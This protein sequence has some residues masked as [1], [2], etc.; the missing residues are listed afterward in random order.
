MKKLL[1]W[2]LVLC[3][4]FSLIG[5]AASDP[6]KTATTPVSTTL[7]GE[8]A[9]ESLPAETAPVATGP[10][11][12]AA[13][14]SQGNTIWLF[15]SIHVGREDFYPL[16]D[17]VM[18]AYNEADALAVEADIVA[19]E[20]N[21]AAATK[22]ILGTMYKDGTKVADHI[23]A[24]LYERSVEILR[25]GGM[26]MPTMDMFH[27]YTW[28]SSIQELAMKKLSCNMSLGIDRHLIQNAKDTGKT[29]LE[30]ESVEFQ[31][32]ILTGF[33]DEINALSLASAIDMYDDPE[34]ADA[35]ITEMMDLWQSGDEAA[36]AAYLASEDDSMP[37]EEQA[38]YAQ[39]MQVL[40][41]DRNLTMTEWA[42]AALA[43]GGDVFIC[44]GAAH[45]IGEGALV[46]LLTQR[47]YT[48]ERITG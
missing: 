29:L 18:D 37:P 20:S 10:I 32:G 4:C 12:Y 7:A 26:Y 1:A 41:T 47:G 17:Y 38:L 6:E 5:C 19:F 48:V 34:A 25:E 23:P 16:P 33:S 35:K 42:E 36:F 24:E 15:G 14:D 2:I 11:L 22:L 8:T 21:T 40:Q 46:D 45:V 28:E 3:L 43:D 13:T 44:V 31:F 9:T 39:Y 27:V 30:V